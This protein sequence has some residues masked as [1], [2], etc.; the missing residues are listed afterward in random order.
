MD[1]SIEGDLTQFHE[2]LTM[3]P[4]AP[5]P[6][7]KKNSKGYWD[8]VSHIF[9]CASHALPEWRRPVCNCVLKKLKHTKFIGY[10][11]L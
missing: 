3:I 9:H 11:T 5:P 6:K 8:I 7:K 4:C 2:L 1:D 10:T